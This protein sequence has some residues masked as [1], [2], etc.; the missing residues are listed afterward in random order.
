MNS[1]WGIFML[2]VKWF[3][4]MIYRLKN[5]YEY[6]EF[7]ENKDGEMESTRSEITNDTFN[8]Y[9]TCDSNRTHNSIMESLSKRSRYKTLHKSKM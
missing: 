3:Q 1:T 8:T 4:N 7:D 5:K 6:V 9:S 2:I